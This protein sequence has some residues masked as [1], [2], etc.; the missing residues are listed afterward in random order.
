MELEAHFRQ[1]ETDECCKTLSYP[2]PDSTSVTELLKTFQHDS[3]QFLTQC[4]DGSECLPAEGMV[5]SVW[6]TFFSVLTE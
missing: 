2:K 1:G 6:F 3:N 4:I 5:T